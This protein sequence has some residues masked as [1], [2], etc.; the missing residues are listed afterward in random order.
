MIEESA[1]VVDCE[2]DFAIVETQVKAA[3]GSC[4]SAS[5]CSTSVLSGLFKRRHNRLRV[6]NSI[7]A[8]PGQRVVIGLQER[9]L[10][11]ASLMAYLMPLL[12]LILGAIAAQQAA[13]HWSWSA[14][15]LWSI[16]G[17]LLGLIIGLALLRRFSLRSRR[18]PNYQAVILRPDIGRPVTFP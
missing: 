4:N 6:R 10:V 11:S 13:L 7:R 1:L 8:V 18:D 2:Q 15:E 9:A 17:G 14:T 5:G 3:C 12:F 16:A